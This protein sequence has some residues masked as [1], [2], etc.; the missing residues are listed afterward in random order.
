MHLFKNSTLQFFY[1]NKKLLQSHRRQYVNA[2]L[3]KKLE[4]TVRRNT[5]YSHLKQGINPSQQLILKIFKCLKNFFRSAHCPPHN[6][7]V[8]SNNLTPIRIIFLAKQKTSTTLKNK[9]REITETEL[10]QSRE[11]TETCREI[12]EDAHPH[13]YP[14]PWCYPY[15]RFSNA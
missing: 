10:T 4:T 7:R 13:P 6:C 9:G 14:W 2:F 1:P 11:V 12:T 8:E 3:E 15:P 5:R